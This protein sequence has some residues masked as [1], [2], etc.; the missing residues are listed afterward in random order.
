MSVGMDM[1]QICWIKAAQTTDTE[2]GATIVEFSFCAFFLIL[3]L[4]AFFDV[5]LGF[6]NWLMLRHVTEESTREI[7]VNLVTDFDCDDIGDYLL[8]TGNRRLMQDLGADVAPEGISWRMHGIAAPATDT[9]AKMR[10]TGSF[11]VD[12]YFLC[13][14]FPQGFPITASSESVL[15]IELGNRTC[16]AQVY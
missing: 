4:G 11:S 7:A 10:I 12:C 9:F 8:T 3:I 6:H 13:S 5:G 2:Q 1:K 16:A 15:E 14:L